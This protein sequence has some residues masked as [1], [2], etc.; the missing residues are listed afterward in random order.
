MARYDRA[1]GAR[2]TGKASMARG[3]IEAWA[4]G[5]AEVVV[6]VSWGKDSV[7]VAELAL[8]S[9]AADR[10]RLVW[11]RQ[12]WFENPDCPAVRDALLARHPDARYEERWVTSTTPRRWDLRPGQV[13]ARTVPTHRA[14]SVWP[15]ERVTGI[16][17]AES[18]QRARSAAVHGEATDRTCR[19]I[20]RWSTAEVFGFLAA[21][22]L[23]VHPAYAMT[24]RA[25]RA[26]DE[27]RVHSLGGA[28]GRDW[29]AGWEDA[30]YGDAILADRCGV[31]VMRALPDSQRRRVATPVLVQRVRS[32][33]EGASPRDVTAAVLRLH[34][35]GLVGRWERYGHEGWWRW[36]DRPWPIPGA[37]TAGDL[38]D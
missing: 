33:V 38:A 29:R 8:T 5:R 4:E 18:E 27:I 11:V 20:L 3:C 10:V 24:T 34:R 19:P 17:A 15:A 9:Q 23:P 7:A 37:A 31:A 21:E 14:G 22:G 26:R 16:R 36:P 25:P 1:Y 30:H 6:S 35:Q 32:V 12:R 2:I 28:D 13:Q